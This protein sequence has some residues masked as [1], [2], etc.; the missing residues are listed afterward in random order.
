[1]DR[2]QAEV[3]KLEVDA[4][5][6]FV[7]GPA[8]TSDVVRRTTG[9]THLTPITNSPYTTYAEQIQIRLPAARKELEQA[10]LVLA[11]IEDAARKDG[12][13]SGQLY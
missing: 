3:A 13:G 5:N 8:P 12:V 1:V 2:L 7:S 10:K 4:K 6:N 11:R 9:I